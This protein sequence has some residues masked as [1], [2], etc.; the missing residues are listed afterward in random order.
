MYSEILFDLD[1]TVADSGKGIIN[2]TA[3]TLEKMGLKVP[4]YSVLR[5][6]VG[7]PPKE[8]LPSFGVPQDRVEEAGKIYR[9][10]YD[11]EG[12]YLESSLYDGITELLKKLKD[13]G[14]KVYIA[15]SKP[16]HVALKLIDY[17]GIT[18]LFDA[19]VGAYYPDNR[20]TKAQVLT[21]L[22]DKYTPRKPLM[23]GDTDFDVIG[24]DKMSIPCVGVSWGFGNKES[25][26]KL[27]AKAVVDTADELFNFIVKT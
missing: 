22:L 4:E 16:E 19:I 20:I 15:T 12:G 26:L 18:H 3:Y 9:N 21:Y 17:L 10:R 14:F 8:I 6:M 27:G 25:M 23:V 5:N 13:N 11:N 2:S 24:A 1:G 7:P